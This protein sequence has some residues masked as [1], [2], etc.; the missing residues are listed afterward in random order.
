MTQ[1]I[2]RDE[3]RRRYAQVLID[4]GGLDRLTAFQA[5]EAGLEMA[6]DWLTPEDAAR[7]EMTYWAEETD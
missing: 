4:E 5:A 7:E 3:W 2:S 1:V 6:D